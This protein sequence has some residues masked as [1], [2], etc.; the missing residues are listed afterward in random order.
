MDFTPEKRAE[1]LDSLRKVPNVS[2]AAKHIGVSRR[3]AYQV[4]ETEPEF[5]AAWDEALTE[6]VEWMEAE[7]HRRAF[8]GTDKPVTFQGA[9]TDTYKEFSDTLAIFLLKAHKPDKYRDNAKLEL[10]GHLSTSQMTDDQI[11]A[12]IAALLASGRVQL[13]GAGLTEDFSDLV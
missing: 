11:D 6:G 4:Y 5:A 10:S 7:A 2:R 13:P 8:E 12:E 1:F 9:I 3:R